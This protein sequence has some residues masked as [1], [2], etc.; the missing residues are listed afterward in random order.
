VKEGRLEEKFGKGRIFKP[1][2][3]LEFNKIV[4]FFV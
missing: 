4:Q 2:D 3:G 1:V